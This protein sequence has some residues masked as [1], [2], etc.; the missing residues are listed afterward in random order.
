M[1][2]LLNFLIFKITLLNFLLFQLRWS[3]N[4]LVDYFHQYLVIRQAEVVFGEDFFES[5]PKFFRLHFFKFHFTFCSCFF[6]K[7]RY[8]G[9][10]SDLLHSLFQLDGF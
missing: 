5:F 10:I 3:F 2:T 9:L 8:S 6:Y 1:K 4:F 7:S